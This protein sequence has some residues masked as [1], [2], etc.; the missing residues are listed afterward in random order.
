[1][2]MYVL[3]FDAGQEF[4]DGGGIQS[5]TEPLGPNLLVGHE[6][7]FA[8]NFTFQIGSQVDGLA[9]VGIGTEDGTDGRFYNDIYASDILTPTGTT[10]LGNETMGPIVTRGVIIDVAG[11]KQ[12]N[13][14]TDDYFL[15]GDQPVL[16]DNYRI[17]ID[18]IEKA[19]RRQKVWKRIGP[20]D[21]PILHTGWTHLIGVDD[22]RYLAQ[23]P[24]IYL[25][26]ARYFTDRKV[27]MVATDTW[28]LE[29][30]DPEVTGGNVFPA[31]QELL[32][33]TGIRIGE[34]WVTDAAI[35]DHAYDGV[36]VVTPENAPGATAGSSAPAFLG[37]KGPKPRY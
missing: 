16:R 15:V 3:G 17:T 27:A 29:V 23:E 33:H 26:E 10:K 5:A 28:G 13:G 7:R 18:D 6:E 24:G 32:G 14:D 2:F 9:H 11:L 20:G 30:L 31:H 25:A 36:A 19:L 12:A 37:Q 4:V 8:E 22:N 35:A 34:S 1:M 21:I